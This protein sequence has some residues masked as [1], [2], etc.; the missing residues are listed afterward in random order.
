M[1][2]E[3][4]SVCGDTIFCPSPRGSLGGGVG[5]GQV[6]CLINLESLGRPALFC[7]FLGGSLRA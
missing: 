1:Y 3:V 2:V 4:T 7:P 6:K 5:H